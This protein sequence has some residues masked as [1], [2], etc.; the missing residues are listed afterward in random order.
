MCVR[1]FVSAC[2]CACRCVCAYY[3]QYFFYIL[4]DGPGINLHACVYT[5]YV[6]CLSVCACG[7]DGHNNIILS[8]QSRSTGL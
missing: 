1:V 8:R 2:V 5:E 6:L 7:T 3:L 4:Y